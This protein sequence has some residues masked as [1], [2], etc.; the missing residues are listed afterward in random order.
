MIR[1]GLVE[2]RQAS[3]T[4]LSAHL[5]SS[6]L[7][8]KCRA[9]KKTPGIRVKDLRNKIKLNDCFP[10]CSLLFEMF[11][12]ECKLKILETPGQHRLRNVA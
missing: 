4:H 12:R 3:H 6:V 1:S 10:D 11:G 7:T 2:V 5:E 9:S 8:W